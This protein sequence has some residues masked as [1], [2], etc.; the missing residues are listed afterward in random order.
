MF[1]EGT[2]SEYPF[3]WLL[4]IL[5]HKRETGLLEIASPQQSGYFY[6]KDG[7]IKEGAVGT[8]RGPAAVK[9]A[10]T[11]ENASFKFKQLNA[12]DY[13]EIVWERS[14]GVN[15]FKGNASF[16]PSEPLRT[17][18]N[19]FFNYWEEISALLETAICWLRLQALPKV[20]LRSRALYQSTETTGV[21]L[22]QRTLDSFKTAHAQFAEKWQGR[23]RPVRAVRQALTEYRIA[24][25]RRMIF[26]QYNQIVLRKRHSLN[27]QEVL[28][29]AHRSATT[30]Y[31][32]QFLP[33]LN[34][35]RRRLLFYT[36][37]AE[38]TFQDT[39][40]LIARRMSGYASA[41]LEFSRSLQ[42]NRN[43]F[44]GYLR[45]LEA[46]QVIL[47]DKG[48]TILNRLDSHKT[49]L[50]VSRAPRLPPFP[51]VTRSYST[52]VMEEVQVILYSTGK[53]LLETLNSR[54]GLIREKVATLSS[55]RQ[56]ANFNISNGLK[57]LQVILRGARIILARLNS[58]TRRIREKATLPSFQQVAE[59]NI[60]FALLVFVLLAISSFCISK[61]WNN[62]QAPID[63]FVTTEK[64]INTQ[65]EAKPRQGRRNHPGK[66]KR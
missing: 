65:P 45:R 50:T 63:T 23:V 11:L 40:Y 37:V 20:L 60:A 31:F 16:T 19:E 53:G 36:S 4:E 12:T 62:A 58:Q 52:G 32:P 57:D 9:L 24:L 35:A 15:H 39:A 21:V 7:E 14:F 48:K 27:F 42:K 64:N 28:S 46:F 43:P 56:L 55:L 25:R 17:S 22:A 38:Q 30:L 33:L 2:F 18:V 6:I 47:R 54:K 13:A 5:L 66:R 10:S 41:T 49:L 29:L 26:R 59:S 8:I 51:H 1:L 44:R 61:L 3:S 34:E